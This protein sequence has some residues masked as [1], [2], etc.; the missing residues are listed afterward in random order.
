MVKKILITGHTGFVGTNLVGA[1]AS[2]GSVF[3]LDVPGPPGMLPPEN[4]CTWDRLDD[5]PDADTIIHLAGKAHDTANVSDQQE[6]FEVNLGLTR[7]IFDHFLESESQT[8]IFFSSVKAV[9]D[10]LHN[11]V[12][13]EDHAAEPQTPYGRS[14]LAAEQYIAEKLGAPE[15]H[16]SPGND[17]Q[18][19]PPKGIKT[20][21]KEKRVF[22][23]RPAMIHGPGNKGNLNLLYNTIRRGLPWPLGAF[24]NLRSFT[25]INN[26]IYVVRRIM[27]ES[28]APGTYNL[29]DDEPLATNELVRLIAASAGRKAHIWNIPPLLIKTAARTG[30]LLHLPLNSERLKKLCE[31]YV[32][33]NLKIKNALRIDALPTKAREGMK[34]TLA[35][36]R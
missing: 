13:S 27:N 17:H 18:S 28:V 12:L 31:N 30:D 25:S 19:L 32:V 15:E 6:Y 29:A 36:F 5:L 10:T 21:T 20:G 2:G 3:G 8:F 24:D 7:R 34:Q 1:F 26:V 14:K 9:A 11:T 4:T 35:S 22:I 33:S 16:P 23:L